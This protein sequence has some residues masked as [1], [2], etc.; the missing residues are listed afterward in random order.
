MAIVVVFLFIA[1]SAL[2]A[3]FYRFEYDY[4]AI[5]YLGTTI[6]YYQIYVETWNGQSITISESQYGTADLPVEYTDIVRVDIGPYQYSSGGKLQ[7][8]K[9]DLTKFSSEGSI[10]GF[11]KAYPILT[12]VLD[13]TGNKDLPTNDKTT[14]ESK[15]PGFP[16]DGDLMWDF[17]FDQSTWHPFP[18]IYQHK[19]TNNI[20][21]SDLLSGSQFDV[22][23]STGKY[24]YIRARYD[25]SCKDN[26][27]STPIQYKIVRSSPTVQLVSTTKPTCY[28]N[29][30]GRAT[31]QLGRSL[32]PNELLHFYLSENGSPKTAVDLTKDNLPND[33]IFE[34]PIDLY[35]GIYDVEYQSRYPD[36]PALS[37]KLKDFVT[38]GTT[39]AVTFTAIPTNIS[40]IGNED[41]KIT[42]RASGGTGSGYQYNIAPYSTWLDFTNGNNTEI[43]I[44]TGGNYTLKVRDGNK[45]V[46]D[47]AAIPVDEPTAI[48]A[49]VSQLDNVCNGDNGGN[50][51]L[52]ASGGSGSYNY[53]VTANG[54]YIN[55]GSFTKDES[56]TIS[57]LY[58]NTYQINLT[59]KQ[60]NCSV[61]S[62]NG[63][64][65]NGE[66]KI[67]EPTSIVTAS[68][69]NTTNV[70]C[71]SDESGSITL[72]ASGGMGS[73]YQYSF[74]PYDTWIDFTNGQNTQIPDLKSGEYFLKV[75]DGNGCI[76][77]E[78][79]NITNNVLYTEITEPIL[80]VTASIVSTTNI[81]CKGNESGSI[82]LN[83]S[84]GKGS[85]YQYSY[86]PYE[87]WTDFTNGQNTQ[88]TGLPLGN[89][90]MKVRD[91]NRC[92]AKEAGSANE[93]TL[94]ADIT[95]PTSIVT[96]AITNT[97]NVACKSDQSGSITLN[98]SGGKGS[99]YQ[100][101]Y[102]PYE[103]WT[104][105]TNGQNTQIPN[106]KSGKYYLKVRDG[107]LCIAK[108]TNNITN[109][110]LYTDITEP[111]TVVTA[112]IVS[113]ADISCHDKDNGTITLQASGGTGDGYQY[114]YSPYVTWIDFTNGSNP[115]ITG[116]PAGNYFL[117]V[118]D[119]NRCI[120]KKADKT[121]NILF[122]SISNPDAISITGTVT[123]I[124]CADGVSRGAITIDAT[125][126]TGTLSYSWGDDTNETSKTR[127]NLIAKAYTITVTDA[128]GC[129]GTETFTVK[130]PSHSLPSVS[131]LNELTHGP[132]TFNG[133]DGVITISSTSGTG[134][135]SYSW[136][137]DDKPFTPISLTSLSAGKYS[138]TVADADQNKCPGNMA[139]I[140]FDNP[141]PPINLATTQTD[142][143]CYCGNNGTITVN[144]TRDHFTDEVV[145]YTYSWYKLNTQ[146]GQYETVA[147]SEE[148]SV[149]S[150]TKLTAG[151]YKIVVTDNYNASSSIITDLTELYTQIIP[152]LKATDVSCYGKGDGKAEVTGITGGTGPYTCKWSNNADG[153]VATN[154]S[155]DS[156]YVTITD[157]K[158]CTARSSIVKVEEPSL[159]TVTLKPYN[160]NG[161]D[162]G[163]G[164]ITA[165]V[166]GGIADYSY[167]WSGKDF[168]GADFKSTEISASGLKA[169]DYSLT[170]TDKNGCTATASVSLTQPDP[171]IVNMTVT[172]PV[173]CHGDSDGSL[174][175][176]ASGGVKLT[177]ET[178][179]YTW[180][181]INTDNTE[182]IVST[183]TSDCLSMS[184]SA[185]DYKVEVED[186]Y[187]N[188]LKSGNTITLDDATPLVFS[189]RSITDVNCYDGYTG[190]IH[191][192]T[193]GGTGS[194]TY[195]ND[196]GET[197]SNNLTGLHAGT[198]AVKIKDTN[199]CELNHT[200]TV[201]QPSAPL[202]VTLA[203]KELSA[204]HAKDATLVATV[205]GGTF[206]PDKPCSF[207]W[208]GSSSKTE[209]A[210][211]LASGTY[212][213]KVT[214][215]NGCTAEDSASFID[216]LKVDIVVTDT[217]RCNGGL[218]ELAARAVGGEPSL[219]GLLYKYTWYKHDIK[220]G[221]ST[222]LYPLDVLKQYDDSVKT[223]PEGYYSVKIDDG[224]GRIVQTAPFHLAQPDTIKFRVD[225]TNVSC[226]GD[227]NGSIRVT[228]TGGSGYYKYIWN[229]DTLFSDNIK[230]RNGLA[231]GN[232]TVQVYDSLFDCAAVPVSRTITITE[233]EKLTLN[234]QK[235][236]VLVACDGKI[237]AIVAGGT[238]PYRFR[239]NDGEET[240]DSVKT[241]LC[242]GNYKVQVIDK[243]QCAAT[244]SILLPPPLKV[245][246]NVQDSVKCFGDN[247][248]SLVV[249]AQGGVPYKTG[250]PYKY[251]WKKQNAAS[252]YEGLN[253]TIGSNLRGLTAGW[254]ALNIT[255]SIGVTLRADSIFYLPEPEAL[256]I[257]IQKT[258]VLC[259]GAS[260]G[261]I[262]AVVTGGLKPYT[263]KWSNNS[264]TADLNS[265]TAGV[266]TLTATDRHGCTKQQSVIIEQHDPLMIGFTN[267]IAP[268][269]STACDGSLTASVSGGVRPYT[270][271]WSVT[272]ATTATADHLCYGTFYTVT[273]TDSVGCSA[274]V[275]KTS[276]FAPPPF[277][278]SLSVQDSIKCYGTAVGTIAAR[279]SGGIPFTAGKPYN[280]SWYKKNKAGEYR[281]IVDSNDSTI[282]QLTS[283]WYAFNVRDAE[284]NSST[285]SVEINIPEPDPI[286][287]TISQK[288][289][290]CNGLHNGKAS[291]SVV[292]G[293]LP[294]TY[295]WSNNGETSPSIDN[296]A[297]G[298]YSIEVTDKHGCI[299]RQSVTITEPGLLSVSFQPKLISEHN[300]CDG[301]LKA[302][303][304]GGTAPFSYAWSGVNSTADAVSSLCAADYSVTV[305]DAHGCSANQK[306]TLSNPPALRLSLVVQDSIKCNG[307]VQGILVATAQG[308]IPFTSGAKYRYTWK[309]KNSR[310]VFETMPAYTDSMATDLAT[311]TYACTITDA[312]GISL[313]QDSVILL[314]E[315]TELQ[316]A[317]QQ[318]NI[319][320]SGAAEGSATVVPSG[321]LFPYSYAWSTGD[322]T[323]TVRNLSAGAYIVRV[324][325]RNGCVAARQMYISK[326]AP[327]YL[328]LYKKQP[329]CYQSCDG[330]IKTTVSGGIAPYSFQWT[331]SASTGSEAGSLCAGKY[332]LLVTDAAGCTIQKNDS[333]QH[334]AQLPLQ[335]GLNRY[336][337]SGQ[338]IR[339]DISIPS[340]TGITYRWAGPDG[341]MATT[342][343]VD[344]KQ[345]GTY[346]A[347]VTNAVGCSNSGS[348]TLSPSG[349]T[350]ANEFALPTQAF[351]NERIVI[352][353]TTYPAPDSIR[354]VLPAKA[355]ILS[356]GQSHA[357][358]LV[359]DTG[360]YVIKM[361]S[362]K[363]VCSL[364]QEKEMI[365][366]TR[367]QLSDIGNT[368]T[369]FIQA[370][371]ATPNPSHGT[372][373]TKV[374]LQG[375]A[376]IQLK[377]INILS[378][379]TAY[380]IKKT[381]ESIYELPIN[382][383]VLKGTYLLLLETPKGSSTMKVIIF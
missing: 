213:L 201:F 26:L 191:F 208:I 199:K 187:K 343:A 207:E 34:Y 24:V 20:S 328:F 139:T 284:L 11:L 37:Q 166:K 119:K 327:L 216:P 322:K 319:G 291:A 311:G 111:T 128:N 195:W 258:D 44:A 360:V 339:Y 227:N 220:T 275:T 186:T 279:V 145:S 90:T 241:L 102:P 185:G 169:G 236:D 59:D 263:L 355:Q 97:T 336:I 10:S 310:R 377:L 346:T 293:V 261:A 286:V 217:I 244:A 64:T 105:F 303:V 215:N 133:S 221:V 144:I 325:D 315:P 337:C 278:V 58:S 140:T 204:F 345:P 378:S 174:K 75:R 31:F 299:S 323:A 357:E 109:D 230:E 170:V 16:Y 183:G 225:S 112:Y 99:G 158:G 382:I 3:Q 335:L 260:T 262:S 52:S 43:P 271:H 184:G 331:G 155:T 38:I 300:V 373:E 15:Y 274:Q 153:L 51:M 192:T 188:K 94:Y 33:N 92:V 334:P 196:K 243:N 341:F 314:P 306:I 273:V 88:I 117:K 178:Y 171:L 19:T 285:E 86:P 219:T 267:I 93:K 142:V 224:H 264:T 135:Y 349:I 302:V 194:Y 251:S 351:V 39:S 259:H 370:F 363:G 107:N 223:L 28:G 288:N 358:F 313:H 129:T 252:I 70:A 6:P 108:E 122:A 32:Y 348:V 150:N 53:T 61:K 147:K 80:G 198:Y 154:L 157:A 96:A 164:S 205:S 321:G 148:S 290:T 312:N 281:S 383:S 320:C 57:N 193:T 161:F 381:G 269:T 115:Q 200:F 143:T 2:N 287:L 46:S 253:D 268:T 247:N 229:D 159:L 232:Y 296:L 106:L 295:K 126:G 308:G 87:T 298:D 104:D 66:I 266:Y 211:G 113:T 98:A 131:I 203:R 249:Y 85:G 190:E 209:T 182:T 250:K 318:T 206:S 347:S 84:G 18:Y 342:P 283:G 246:I 270:Y 5:N 163:N 374:V 233:P 210:S 359:A 124:P 234:L 380:Q 212:K 218:G 239:W 77:K 95:E 35:P 371:S 71:K 14:I 344:L 280:Y 175:A 121:E 367:S 365:V 73:G 353:N 179:K 41:G 226:K 29:G 17:S 180:K 62:W 228:A 156:Y 1:C 332:S 307:N 79:N 231:M 36:V 168:T 176:T 76:A 304:R 134:N 45:C 81:A 72:N 25:C 202:A 316:L 333:L 248:G 55:T 68:I 4:R 165:E 240:V 27:V 120:A 127:Y 362:Y 21:A 292:G 132:S 49:T 238:R 9:E 254:Y 272:N 12:N 317:I 167:A 329:L 305:T 47:D 23:T 125:G 137:K 340:K 242:N 89:Y 116:L 289:I 368:K 22:N 8:W 151:K 255:D 364:E 110:I 257:R 324:T 74:P 375:K 297:S 172:H 48:S 100:Y 177:G 83:A 379:Q 354:W 330:E 265:L 136:E 30:N 222:L 13:P 82:T 123:N 60:H 56:V 294:Y 141:T 256:A 361:I 91:G 197:I 114:S 372:F 160:P 276:K 146:S 103:T 152:T 50:I 118:R 67:A 149:N 162:N 130:P 69:T 189:T 65:T 235:R 101:S 63:A 40:C 54:G 237:E 350:V 277:V 352:V 309:K 78:T 42:L 369:P 173:S 338:T 301:S 138:V 326:A 245:K 214:D 7:C 366:S 282:T 181:K 376:G 356:G